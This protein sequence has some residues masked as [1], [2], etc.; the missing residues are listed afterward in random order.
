MN[1]APR[2]ALARAAEAYQEFTGR[3]A[4]HLDRYPLELDGAAWELGVVPEIHY[5]A[6]RDGE[7]FRFIHKFRHRSRP[8]LAASSDGSQLYLLGGAY[9]V[10]DRGIIDAD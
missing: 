4:R 8:L 2:P 1:P 9:T 6:T 3:E 5:I 7:T 10:T